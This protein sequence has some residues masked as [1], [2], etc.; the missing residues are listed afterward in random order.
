VVESCAR[1]GDVMLDGPEE[2][3]YRIVKSDLPKLVSK[4]QFMKRGFENNGDTSGYA[5]NSGETVTVMASHIIRPGKEKEF[6]EGEEQVMEMLKSTSG[7]IGYQILKRI[8][9]SSMG[10]GHVTVESL[11]EDMK[12]SS[13]SKLKPAAEVW[14]GYT[15]PAQYLVM[16]EFDSL[17]AAQLGMPHVNVKPEILQVHGFKVFNNCIQMPS[18]Y[19][20]DSM[21]TEQSYREILQGNK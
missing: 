21:F 7:V 5:L 6:E 14:E 12:D 13:G 15:V 20:S 1:C 17:E 2:P 10:S 4:T 19:I 11:M 16:V 8:G 3:V 9:L 18:V